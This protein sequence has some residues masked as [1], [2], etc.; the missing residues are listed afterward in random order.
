MSK[1]MSVTVNT[2]PHANN[3][4]LNTSKERLHS[5]RRCQRRRMQQ[6]DERA[7]H[8]EALV[9]SAEKQD[10][11]AKIMGGQMIN[12]SLSAQE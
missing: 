5:S 8:P 11:K 7:S 6:P 12:E 2:D 4:E 3:D 10:I 1:M 9:L